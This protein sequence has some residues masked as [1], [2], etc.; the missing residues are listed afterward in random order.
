MGFVLFTEHQMSI[1]SWLEVRSVPRLDPKHQALCPMYQV[2]PLTMHS[3]VPAI[4][5]FTYGITS[6]LSKRNFS[7]RKGPIFR[8]ILWP[9]Q[10][11]HRVL[12]GIK[13]KI[14]TLSFHWYAMVFC[15]LRGLDTTVSQ[16][17][18]IFQKT[19]NAENWPVLFSGRT[20][21]FW[22]FFSNGCHS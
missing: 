17:S 22:H 7:C 15:G 13:W 4:E 2:C 11:S 8:A 16:T 20:Q 18:A 3:C 1:L 12:L 6:P 14:W 10:W 19:K 5:A 21:I 9:N